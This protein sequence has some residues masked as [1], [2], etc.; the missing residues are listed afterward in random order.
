MVPRR[1]FFSH[2]SELSRFPEG[3]SF[4]AA[5][6]SAVKR[7]GDA[8]VDMAYFTARDS[9]PATYCREQVRRCQVY[10]GI[11]GFR[12]GSPVRDEPEVSYTEL[13]FAEA[14]DAGLE[15]LV[16]LLDDK[17]TGLP[18]PRSALFDTA[19]GDRQD[20]FRCRLRE[21]GL[22]VQKVGNPDELELLL[23]QALQTSALDREA[24]APA[25]GTTY[26]DLPGLPVV[27]GREG[28]VAR[29]VEG[30]AAL[31]PVSVPVLGAPGIGKSTVC[32]AALH[33]AQVIARFGHRRWF[34]R[35]DGAEDADSLLAAV[36]A[37]LDVTVDGSGSLTAAVCAALDGSP[38][39]LALDN[40]E[41]P[42]TA[43]PLG[44]EELLCRLAARPGTALVATIRGTA[45]PGRLAWGESVAVAPLPLSQARQ[46]FL[47]IA[48]AA[49]ATDSDLDDLLG[50]LDGVAL[51]V[52][53]LAHAAQG[54]P[55]LADLA[56]RWQHERTAL[57]QRHGGGRRELSVPVSVEL[58][59]AG[60]PMTPEALRLLTVLGRLPDGIAHLDLD[61][62]LP[63]AGP[64][65]AAVL[66]QTGLA[67]DQTGRL[68]TLAPIREHIATTRS[69]HDADRDR[70]LAFYCRLASREGEKVGTSTGARAVEQLLPETGNILRMLET[71]VER[72]QTDTL[73]R[74]VLGLLEYMRFTGA[75]TPALLHPTTTAIDT[76]GTPLQRASLHRRLGELA[77]SRDDNDAAE[78]HYRHA[79]D[80]YEQSGRLL[81]QA[82][83]TLGLGDLARARS[84]Y[85]AAERH[86][87]HA[88][89]LYEQTGSLLGQANTTLGL[90]HLARARSDYDAAERHYRHA[91]DLYEQTGSSQVIIGFSRTEANTTL[92]QANAT[93]GLGDLA[94]ARDDYDAAER[95]YRHALDLYEQTGSLLGQA[96]TTLGLGHL[97]RAR[98]DYDA[99][100]R[101]YRHA[102]DL[103]EQIGSLLGQANTTNGLGHLAR[104]RSD[105]DTAEQHNSQD[106]RVMADLSSMSPKDRARYLLQL[107][108]NEE[109]EMGVLLTQL[110]ALRH[111]T[112]MSII[113]NIR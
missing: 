81:G 4:V 37:E 24:D 95:H 88:F 85:D 34:V 77:R 12:Y 14:T 23:L 98:D 66:R 43:D 112:A 105:Y 86:Y 13:E 69:P 61:A 2:T 44:T 74:A 80:L 30:L 5:A 65:A 28:E 72:G 56:R 3:R 58:S 45:R 49:F 59:L 7:A 107:R 35:C 73:T 42:W 38:A 82:N 106:E 110:Q 84:D 104:A 19:Y 53:L 111:Q 17:A 51:A 15:R 75:L 20:A 27:V 83:A 22:T 99:A 96:N 47:N 90:G 41:T 109:D 8:P 63:D 94:C 100:E 67:Y 11:I 103:Y 91:F 79:L 54:Q 97:A 25:A 33:D 39:V 64:R 18:L 101:H 9:K 57:L 16:F 26:G 46:V 50:A 31:P 32:V 48:G 40:L 60:P 21:S 29:V 70:T 1:V 36:A 102:L 108:L 68:R 92:G 93:L 62:L 10:V 71:A 87:R 55:D 113:D 76:H 78:R 52:E 89:D 6:E